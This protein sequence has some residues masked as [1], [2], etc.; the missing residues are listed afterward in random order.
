[1]KRIFI[2]FPVKP[3]IVGGLLRAQDSIKEVY[4]EALVK[5]TKKDSFHITLEFL[6]EIRES[7]IRKVEKIL[8]LVVGNYPII[9]H[10]IGKI[11]AF[12]NLRRPKVLVTRVRDI[13]GS[14][15]RLRED[16]HKQLCVLGLADDGRKWKPHFT[17]G[18]LKEPFKMN[19][20][21]KMV[22]LGISW[23]TKKVVIYESELTSRGPMYRSLAEFDL[24]SQ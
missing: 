5:W 17:L 15:L 1:M 19:A 14:N 12:P 9:Y 16:I 22:P 24:D 4:P 7:D 23:K 21:K 6:G 18:R 3:E 8:Q 10:T 2:A 13:T 20:L 11:Q